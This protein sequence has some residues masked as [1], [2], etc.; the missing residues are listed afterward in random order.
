MLLSSFSL[1]DAPSTATFRK[2]MF[3]LGSKSK[4]LK[5]SYYIFEIITITFNLL[6]HIQ[7]GISN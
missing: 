1:R 4:I 3:L 2:R 6:V 5:I 7:L